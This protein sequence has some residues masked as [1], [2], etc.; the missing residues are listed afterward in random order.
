MII[1][2]NSFSSF[3]QTRTKLAS[4]HSYGNKSVFKHSRKMHSS[5]LQI[6]LPQIFNIRILI[7]S[8]PYASLGSSFFNIFAVSSSK[9]R[10]VL[11]RFLVEKINWLGR[12]LLLSI[13]E[14]CFAKIALKSSIFSLKS[15]TNLFAWKRGGIK[16][17]FLLFK[18]SFSFKAHK[19]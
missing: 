4:F 8:W 3:L 7:W 13:I 19:F 1:F 11:R 10:I 16:I 15:V 17:I 12:L 5:G 18:N 14:H 6:V 2:K 9:N